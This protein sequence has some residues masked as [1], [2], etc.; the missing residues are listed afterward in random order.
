MITGAREANLAKVTEMSH[1]VESF[2]RVSQQH[3]DASRFNQ[4]SRRPNRAST[5]EK[6]LAV[7]ADAVRLSKCAP[8]LPCRIIGF[9]RSTQTN[10]A[11]SLRR[12]LDGLG[13]TR[14]A[15]S[16]LQLTDRL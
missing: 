6:L 9:Q 13:R 3:S 7:D 1:R 10:G 15:H 8:N 11:L 14:L 12:Q 16:V 5:P 2:H 4:T